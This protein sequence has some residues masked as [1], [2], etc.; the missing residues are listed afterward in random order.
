MHFTA[1]HPDR[2]MVEK[3]RAPT[4]TLRRVREIAFG[5]GVYYACTGN[6]HDQQDGATFRHGC[7]A[8]VVARDCYQ[9][10]A[11]GLDDTGH[12][13][14]CGTRCSGRFQGPACDSGRR[15]RPVRLG[16]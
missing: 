12:C 3:P 5:N 8:A 15:R 13:V 9:I 10:E 1:F 11:W 14:Q 16:E 2:K 7:G 6:V 4:D